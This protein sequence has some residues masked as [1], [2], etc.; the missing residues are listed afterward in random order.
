MTK[1]RTKLR[2]SSAPKKEKHALR[3]HLVR[4][5]EPLP[6]IAPPRIRK[7]R[8][9]NRALQRAMPLEVE[10][11]CPLC[12]VVIT[13]FDADIFLSTGRCGPCHEAFDER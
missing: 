1:A 2:E 9:N 7:P 8:R 4:E 6:E 11:H 10:A 13:R 12:E 5:G 3:F